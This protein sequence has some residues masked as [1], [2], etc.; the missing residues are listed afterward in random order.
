[1]LSSA[2]RQGAL[3]LPAAL[4]ASAPALSQLGTVVAAAFHASA[5]AAATAQPQQ[6]RRKANKPAG[7]ELPL[8]PAAQPRCLSEEAREWHDR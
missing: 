5:T 4:A 6:P 7:G 8:G 2:A 1:M 3:R